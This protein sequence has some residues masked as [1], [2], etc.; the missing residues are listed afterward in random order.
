MLQRVKQGTGYYEPR[1]I[2]IDSWVCRR[3][4][5]VGCAN[6]IL[7][8]NVKVERVAGSTDR[9]IVRCDSPSSSSVSSSMSSGETWYLTCHGSRW[10][11]I[12]DLHNCTNFTI[13]KYTTSDCFNPCQLTF[14]SAIGFLV[15]LFQSIL[16]YC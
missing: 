3:V 14:L 10:L 16:V 4:A 6:P 5:V 2:D 7:P 12:A 8:S 9:L 15:Y 1:L 11:G 13:S